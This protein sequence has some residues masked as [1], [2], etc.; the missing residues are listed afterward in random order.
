[1]ENI[2]IKSL[3]AD[4]GESPFNDDI[5]NSRKCLTNHRTKK[6]WGKYDITIARW[7]K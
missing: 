6:G 3:W 7:A 5:L 4:E 1:M 2:T